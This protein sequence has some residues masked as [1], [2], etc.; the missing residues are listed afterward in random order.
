METYSSNDSAI[1][2]INAVKSYGKGSNVLNG[3]YMDVP[4]GAIYGLLGP[5]GCGKT[6]L[7][8]LIIG[9]ET[10]NSGVVNVQI[11]SKMDI[12]YMPQGI[13]LSKYLTVRETLMYYGSLY[14][15]PEEKILQKTAELGE[16]LDIHFFN[17]LIK[18]LS[19]GQ[20]R[21]V[22][23]AVSL[24][25]NPKILILDEPTVGLDPILCSNIWDYLASLVKREN[26]TVIITTHYIQ[27]ANKANIIAF[28]RQG[29]IIKESSPQ[30]ILSHYNTDSLE[31]AF[32]Q[33]ITES[34]K[35]LVIEEPSPSLCPERRSTTLFDVIQNKD[36][37]ISKHRILT[38]FK[39]HCLTISRDFIFF[40]FMFALPVSLCLLL[41]LTVGNNFKYITLGVQNKETDM[42][43]CKTMNSSGCIFDDNYNSTLSCRVINYL[44]SHDYDFIQFNDTETALK[45][46]NKA[47]I[48]AFISFPKNF[49]QGI[50][51]FINGDN[52]ISVNSQLF[53][54]ID[55]ANMLI[56]SQIEGHITNASINAIK[57]E[58]ARCSFGTKFMTPWEPKF[59]YGANVTSQKHTALGVILVI[60]IFY[61]TSV[62]SASF[63]LEEKL[64]GLL[65]RTMTA[66][67]TMFEVIT[68]YLMLHT[69]AGIVQT[70]MLAFLAF[71]ILQ[72]PL[73]TDVYF[74][75]FVVQTL[76]GW[77]G[78]FFGVFVAALANNSNEVMQMTLAMGSVQMFVGGLIW[79]VEA[80]SEVMQNISR[81][82]PMSLLG[83]VLSNAILR[84]W[85]LINPTHINVLI[86]IM[87]NF[88]LIT[89]W[90]LGL[91]LFKKN[92]WIHN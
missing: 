37:A 44:Y 15:M 86:K 54:Y 70:A 23:L 92:P 38:L 85:S 29:K 27:E 66:G 60:C 49:T 31:D 6:T 51:Q 89:L 90:F 62:C 1:R 69:L 72:Y 63:M 19:G 34:S 18:D 74:E 50:Q 58:I 24:L 47:Q 30:N 68:A 45:A 25:H 59:V 42:S 46:V 43:S 57:N 84:G 88:L 75:I 7:L 79:P 41:N 83:T 11:E 33:I 56:K 40:F 9:T 28:M 20:C 2:I 13:C 5:S 10:L 64:D 53:S 82:L 39:K 17:S 65:S 61:Y 76:G 4:T 71:Y 48:Y 52:K 21:R 35:P 91:K 77:L 36:V 32:L 14:N 3:L 81:N 55:K 87:A 26:K 8:N 12:G 78:F 67:V 16:S 73:V 22:S 80:Q